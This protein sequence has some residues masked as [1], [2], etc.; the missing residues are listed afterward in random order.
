MEDTRA[1]ERHI[2]VLSMIVL[3][4]QPFSIVSDPGF[5]Y[6]SYKMDPN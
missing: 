5:N 3:D 2:G 4:L 1:K 6:Y